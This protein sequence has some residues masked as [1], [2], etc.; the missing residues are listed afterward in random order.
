MIQFVQGLYRQIHSLQ[1]TVAQQMQLIEHQKQTISQLQARIDQLE[2]RTKKNSTNSHLPPSAYVAPVRLLSSREKTRYRL[3]GQPGHPGKTL[4]PI[5]NPDHIIVHRVT[6]CAGCGASLEHMP[7]RCRHIHRKET[8]DLE[9][10]V[11]RNS[12]VIWVIFRVD[13]P[14]TSIS[15]STSTRACSLR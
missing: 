9:K 15:M 12:S 10:E 13:T 14:F 3:G 4:Q 7:P 8:V 1:A 5:E 11:P 6:S 2:A